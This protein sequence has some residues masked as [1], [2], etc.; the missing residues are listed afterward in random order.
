MRAYLLALR[1][2]FE[3][4]GQAWRDPRLHILLVLGTGILATGTTFYHIVEGWNWLDSAYFSTVTLATVGYG[5]LH[6]V[7]DIGKAFTIVYILI[8]VGVFVGIFTVISRA[9]FDAGQQL[10]R[11]PQ[12]KARQSDLPPLP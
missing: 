8:G 5:D 9:G 4:I 12:D 1:Q 6:P 10:A 7:T 11:G 2:L 3:I